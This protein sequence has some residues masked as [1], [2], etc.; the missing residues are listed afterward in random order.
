M[1]GAK[2]VSNRLPSL[3][4]PGN[5]KIRERRRSILFRV[6]FIRHALHCHLPLIGQRVRC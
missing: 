1:K 6:N 2:N 4:R 5:L 3:Q